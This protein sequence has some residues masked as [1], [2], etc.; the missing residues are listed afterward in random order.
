MIQ[1]RCKVGNKPLPG[2]FQTYGRIGYTII[3]I[4]FTGGGLCLEKLIIALVK[5]I[6]L[7]GFAFL[8]FVHKSN[9]LFL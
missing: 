3:E 6:M 8:W 4:D 5:K 1:C 2:E 7:F 9:I